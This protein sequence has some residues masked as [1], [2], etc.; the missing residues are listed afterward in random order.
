MYIV[1]VC[2]RQFFWC[3]NLD[4]VS[5]KL[6]FLATAGIT[7]VDVFSL[8]SVLECKDVWKERAFLPEVASLL[9]TKF[10]Q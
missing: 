1:W 9:H 7:K 3:D 6:E 5:A 10:K 4:E 2:S 8:C